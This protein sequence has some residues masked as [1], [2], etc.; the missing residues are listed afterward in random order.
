METVFGKV[1][2]VGIL[3]LFTLVSGVIVS[4]SGRPLNIWLVTVHKLAAVCT[5]VLI[6]MAVH[7]AYKTADGR[8]FIMIG[9]AALSAVFFVALI[10]SGAF[11]TREEMELPAFVLRIHQLAP[12]MALLSTSLTLV[13]LLQNQGSMLL[14]R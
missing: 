1:L 13:L 11:L 10:A 8:V 6:Y 3:F 5:V 4:R 14:E 9:L 2:I 7:Q 12:L